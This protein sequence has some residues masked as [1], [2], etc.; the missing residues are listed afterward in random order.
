MV[1]GGKI[2]KKGKP[3]YVGGV[4]DFFDDMEED[5]FGLITLKEKLQDLGYKDKEA[6][7]Y[8]YL[9]SG[10]KELKLDNEI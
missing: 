10:L 2:N 1:H 5:E 4:V 7:F 3:K 8:C 6:T 9:Q